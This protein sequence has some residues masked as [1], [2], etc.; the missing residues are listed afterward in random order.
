MRDVI[1]K[2]PKLRGRGVNINT[3]RHIPA[4]P[5]NLKA[6]NELYKDGETVSPKTLYMRDAVKKVGGNL[7]PV[8]ILSMGDIKKKVNIVDCAVSES[9]KEKLE[10]A[11]SKI[12]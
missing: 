12:K 4:Q 1:K 2:L 3:S 6:L 9:A 8:K 5:V 7:P 10:K 11:G